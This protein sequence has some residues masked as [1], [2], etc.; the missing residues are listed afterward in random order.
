MKIDVVGA[1]PG[2]LYF[3]LLAKKR[4]P[5]F[6]ITVYERNSQD[7]TYGFGVALQNSSWE[8]L[9]ADDKA[10]L[11]DIIAASTPIHGQQITHKDTSIEFRSPLPNAGIE[12]VALL[13]TDG[14]QE[15]VVVATNVYQRTAQGWRMVAHHA[16]PGTAPTHA[17]AHEAPQVLH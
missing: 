2:G 5:S 12:R 17:E 8:Y 1:G 13:T 15:A 4:N 3:A 6:Q 9:A 16:S 11:K 14:T 7:A 10:C